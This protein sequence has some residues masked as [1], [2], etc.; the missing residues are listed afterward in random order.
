MS[1]SFDSK[2]DIEDNVSMLMYA[3]ESEESEK[4]LH[5][6]IQKAQFYK[7][8]DLEFDARVAYLRQ[9]SWL[10]K[11]DKA[12]ATMPWLLKRL[13]EGHNAEHL[14]TVL[15]MYKWIIIKLP[16]FASIS[17][18]QIEQL[19]DDMEKRF[20]DFG[21]GMRI[22]NYFRMIVYSDMGRLEQSQK[23][24]KLYLQDNATCALDDCRACQPNNLL[25]VYFNM[26]DYDAYFVQ[27]APLLAR[28]V[29]C[30]EVPDY[31]YPGIAFVN[32]IV[33][34]HE[35]AMEQ[36]LLGRKKIKWKKAVLSQAGYLL[37]YYGYTKDFVKGRATLEKQI[38]FCAQTQP[39]LS[40]FKFY[41]GTLVY[42]SALQNEGKKQVKL[43]VEHQ[44]LLPVQEG[45][46]YVQEAL[47][48]LE[49]K[50]DELSHKLD[51]RNQNDFYQQEKAY[52]LKF[53]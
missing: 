3:D 50:V 30:K 45:V 43:K 15:W 36:A 22:V 6:C 9:V 35:L 4:V 34:N 25:G 24:L 46:C 44:N 39:E 48:W 19:L 12:I 14:D 8:K 52:F 13:D 20:L 16:S 31:S 11:K 38:D 27:A 10:N 26:K 32:Y 40:L 51:H 17:V 49:K 41:L 42:F 5:K 21:T 47:P 7:D 18:A 1:Y 23:Y 2:E 37:A 29:T 53:L 33:G 28:K